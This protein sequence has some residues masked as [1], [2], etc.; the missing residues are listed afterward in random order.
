MMKAIIMK[1]KLRFL[2]GSCPMPDPFD[3]TFEPWVRCNNLVL[4]WL[5]NSVVPAIS[6]SLVYTDDASQAWSD[7]K[8]CFSRADRVRVSS[9]RRDLYALRQGSFSVTEYFTKL[10]GLWEELE[11]SRPIPNCS[12]PVPCTCEAMRNAKKFR[13]GTVVGKSHGSSSINNIE[14][15]EMDT[16]SIVDND[17]RV[18]SFS[19]EEYQALMALLKSSKSAAPSHQ[20]NS[21]STHIAS[22]SSNDKQ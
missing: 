13:D 18:A 5:I 1:N 3:P 8:A 12:C 6:Q 20:V 15:E 7:L 19:S 16:K 21:F 4:S 2:D 22:S 17:N 9:L 11:L 14:C 10:K